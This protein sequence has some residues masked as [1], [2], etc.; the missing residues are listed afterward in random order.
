MLVVWVPGL[1]GCFCWVWTLWFK[2][3]YWFGGSLLVRLVLLVD[4]M[5]LVWDLPVGTL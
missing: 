4:R 3:V 1:F 5:V 2:R